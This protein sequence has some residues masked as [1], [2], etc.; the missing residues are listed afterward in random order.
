MQFFFIVVEVI[1][2][3]I[4]T[5][6]K[7]ILYLR[8]DRNQYTDDDDDRN[9]FDY[10]NYNARAGMAFWRASKIILFSRSGRNNILR[11]ACK[12]YSVPD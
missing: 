10:N 6:L 4:M 2:I 11:G 8:S 3:I 7:S 5:V 9:I 12:N 1:L